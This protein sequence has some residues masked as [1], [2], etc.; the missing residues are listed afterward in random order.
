MK[1]RNH[2]VVYMGKPKRIRRLNVDRL[3]NIFGFRTAYLMI[4]NNHKRKL[5]KQLYCKKQYNLLCIH[6]KTKSFTKQL[7]RSG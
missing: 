3:A 1:K 7:I 6:G 2:L 4:Q 5:M